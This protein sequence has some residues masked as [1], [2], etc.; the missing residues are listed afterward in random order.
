MSCPLFYFFLSTS[1][2]M[3]VASYFLFIYFIFIFY[4][5]FFFRL[6]YIIFLY[7]VRS[8]FFNQYFW[9]NILVAP[10]YRFFFTS[11]LCFSL[12]FV[13]I[14]LRGISHLIVALENKIFNFVQKINFQYWT[15]TPSSLVVVA[16]SN[17]ARSSFCSLCCR[18]YNR[19]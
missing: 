4:L 3:S 8:L 2:F 15:A 19:Q 17:N 11:K 18:S 13:A 6:C 9:D 14:L 10:N 5:D 1:Y 16:T 7:L 12:R